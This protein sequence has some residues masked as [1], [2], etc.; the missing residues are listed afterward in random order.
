MKTSS[1]WPAY[2][3]APRSSAKITC[4][5]RV[6][7]RSVLSPV[8]FRFGITYGSTRTKCSRSRSPPLP[9]HRA[10]GSCAGLHPPGIL[11]VDVR[12]HVESRRR[13]HQDQGLRQRS[14]L[15]I[16]PRVHLALQNL[17]IDRRRHH[18]A[19][20]I[21]LHTSYLP[22]GFLDFGPGDVQVRLPRTRLQAR[23]FRLR[24]VHASLRGLHRKTPALQVFIPYRAL[25]A[26]AL[27]QVELHRGI[28]IKLLGLADLGFRGRQVFGPRRHRQ[29]FEPRFG[30]GQRTVA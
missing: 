3:G 14:C 21:R 5:T 16:F 12:P 23:Q 29:L 8:R 7:T 15:R 30:Q 11:L 10:R 24:P 22:A 9:A 17:A 1:C 18:Q 13:A 20:Q 19:R 6:S 2:T 25:V 4:S 26:H 27:D 28:L